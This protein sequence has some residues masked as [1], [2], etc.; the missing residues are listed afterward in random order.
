GRIGQSVAVIAEK[1]GMH[2]IYYDVVK[3]PEVPTNFTK[4]ALEA[5]FRESDIVSLH[6]PLTPQ[7]E[8]I[9]NNKHLNLMKPT[10]FLINTSRGQLIN[11]Q[12]LANALNNNR[13]AGAG[14]D[15]LSSEPPNPENP[16]LSAKNCYITP[17]IAW[18]TKAARIRLMNTVVD[19]VRCFIEGHS[20]NRI[21]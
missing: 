12:D 5:L 16:L 17:H 14:L 19:N 2:I 8:Q 15:V 4:V 7:T 10:A 21:N 3:Q 20:T 18:A 9:M 13:I 11:E 6:C 1:F